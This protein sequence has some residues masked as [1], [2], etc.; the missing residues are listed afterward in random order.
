MS[1][2]AIYSRGIAEGGLRHTLASVSPQ[3]SLNVHVAVRGRPLGPADYRKLRSSIKE[4]VQTRLGYMLQDIQRH[5]RILPTLPLLSTPV[6]Q[7]IPEGT[8]VGRPFFLTDFK[9]HS[10]LVEATGLTVAPNCM[11]GVWKWR[12]R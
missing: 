3:T 4:I 5:G 11:I 2:G 1:L 12:W 9:E 10:Q 7:A 8:P 6:E